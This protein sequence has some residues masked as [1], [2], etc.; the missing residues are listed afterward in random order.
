MRSPAVRPTVS[1]RSDAVHRRHRTGNQSASWRRRAATCCLDDA[2][3][4]AAAA[5]D[6]E[7]DA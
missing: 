4:A 5:A 3:H 6:D 1:G 2:A 7:D